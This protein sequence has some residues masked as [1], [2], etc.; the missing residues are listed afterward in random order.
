MC[1]FSILPKVERALVMSLKVA[2][3]ITKSGTSPGTCNCK[4]DCAKVEI[5]NEKSAKNTQF[6]W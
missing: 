6:V 1:K 5:R 4:L 3:N 2:W